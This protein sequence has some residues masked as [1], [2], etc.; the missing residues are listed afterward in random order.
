M[1]LAGLEKYEEALAEYFQCFLLED[2]C[3]EFLRT[4]MMKMF[5][6]LITRNQNLSPALSMIDK[7]VTQLVSNPPQPSPRHLRSDQAD[8]EDLDCS[9]C[10]R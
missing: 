2:S 1:A 5:Q 7:A 3:S 6:L 4:E 9:L 10:F 8:K